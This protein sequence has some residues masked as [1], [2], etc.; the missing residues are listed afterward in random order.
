[1][2]EEVIIPE[3][4][5]SPRFADMQ[6]IWQQGGAPS[7]FDVELRDFLNQ[8][9]HK[10]IGRRGTTECPPRSCGL[11]PYDF[12]LW[13]ILKND[14]FTQK[15]QNLHQLRQMIEQ[16]FNQQTPKTKESGGKR[17]KRIPK[18]VLFESS[19]DEDIDI[20]KLCNDSDD[21]EIV[22]NYEDNRAR[23]LCLAT[24]IA[25]AIGLLLAVL[26]LRSGVSSILVWRDYLSELFLRFSPN[27]KLMSDAALV[28]AGIPPLLLTAMAKAEISNVKRNGIFIEQESY[29]EVEK[30]SHF[31]L[32]GHPKDF[33]RASNT[34]TD[35]HEYNIYTDG[36][37]LQ[38]ENDVTLVGCAFVTY[39]NTTEVHSATFRLAP[40]CSVFQ[41][42]LFAILQ[43]V[44]WS[45]TN[46]IDS[47]IHSDSQSALQTI[48][49]KYNLH[50]IAVEIRSLILKFEGRI[51]L[52]WVRG[53][54][55][56][57]KPEQKPAGARL[58]CA[59]ASA[60]S[61]GLSSAVDRSEGPKVD[62]SWRDHSLNCL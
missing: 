4:Q 27:V 61:E 31:Q 1:M 5:N 16:S 45:I 7:H 39:Y 26:E 2:L 9:F 28:I 46:G 24:G 38:K 15:S 41:A 55:V 47:C 58:E 34:C 40:M 62:R 3:L 8:Q 22:M 53:H 51:C 20:N 21:Y 54:T 36:S 10:W 52:M 57:E 30:R 33:H 23:D 25:Q 6:F 49:D 32:T 18:K 43:A 44:K 56:S 35:R 14:V 13:G 59:S 60:S 48:D 37:R 50:S 11:T 19:S 17:K 12:L 29:L 42:E